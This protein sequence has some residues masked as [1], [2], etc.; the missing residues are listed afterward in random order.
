VT[1][2]ELLG[3]EYRY[4]TIFTG[5]R[6]RLYVSGFGDPTFGSWRYTQTK[7]AFLFPEIIKGLRAAGIKTVNE[8]VVYANVLDK[9]VPGGW[10]NDDMAN[11]YGAGA[12]LFNWNENQYDLTFIPGAKTGDR[13]LI[14]TATTN[15]WWNFLNDCKTGAPGS[16]DNAY[17]YFIPGSPIRLIQGTVPAG[18]KRFKISGADIEPYRSFLRSFQPYAS[19]NGFYKG[20]IRHFPYAP[21]FRED[22]VIKKNALYINYS[23][24]LDSIIYWFNKKSINLYGEA[25]VKTIALEKQGYAST[26]S[27]VAI[28]RRFWKDK[29]L[30]PEELNM[31]DG[32][33]LSPLNRV[34][35]HAQVEIL[36]Y[37]KTKNWFPAFYEALPEY[38]GMKMK[39]GTISDVKGYCGYHKAKDGREYIFSFLI[40]NYS[41]KTGPVVSKMY[42]V[43][44]ELK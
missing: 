22:S 24:P 26:D 25:L 29:G 31:Y 37:A 40:N 21:W 41:G 8:I 28:V 23:P 12:Q 35:T 4:K 14:D 18:D 13:A 9:I 5:D 33:G 44:D 20:D 42:K 34:T 27:G 15:E 36:K 39:S 32:S 43:L 30:D 1:A 10:I 3:K 2:F 19:K 7:E 17:I 16:G 6:N 38:N 11:Y